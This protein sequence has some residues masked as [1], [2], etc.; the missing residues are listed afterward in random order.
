MDALQQNI[1][2]FLFVVHHAPRA[3]GTEELARTLDVPDARTLYRWQDE[4]AD[5]LI[6]YPSVSFRALGLEHWHLYIDDPSTAWAGFEYAISGEWVTNHPGRRTLYLH[7]LAPCKHRAE[8]RQLLDDLHA[9]YGHLENITSDDGW[10]VMRD[11]N[12]DASELDAVP[13]SALR[14][15]PPVWDVVERVPLLVPV[16]FES[17]EQRRNLPELWRRIYERLDERTWDFLPRGARRLPNNGKTYIK[18]AYALL[19]HTGLFRQNIIRYRPLTAI[20]PTIFLHLQS[21]DLTGVI[22]AFGKRAHLLDVHPISNTEV[23]LRLVTTH[24][25]M[26]YVMSGRNDLP[27]I[28]EWY[29]LDQ[30]C[31]QRVTPRFAYEQLFDPLTTEWLFPR[32]EIMRRLTR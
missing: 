12:D 13:V 4:F 23:H 8:F 5:D 24:A 16:I 11:L 27:R 25:T 14:D 15:A 3:L 7:C 20:G 29:L 30:L 2:R 21:G 32:E 26:Q 10:Q 18:D 28:T 6:Y 17:V 22:N 31:T 19:N 1:L 9:T